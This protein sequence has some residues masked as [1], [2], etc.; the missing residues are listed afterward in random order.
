MEL[1]V[2]ILQPNHSLKDYD[3]T[4]IHSETQHCPYNPWDLLK[5]IREKFVEFRRNICPAWI[6]EPCYAA[7]WTVFKLNSAEVSLLARFMTWPEQLDI[8]QL[9]LQ[10]AIARCHPRVEH[11]PRW[12][13]SRPC[14][15]NKPD[16]ATS[17]P[18]PFLKHI[19]YFRTITTLDT[20]SNFRVSSDPKS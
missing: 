4:I 1:V 3:L 20:D 19:T 12:R 5:V 14:H 13:A 16:K 7:F 2:M 8:G 15:S 10:S 9:Q 11:K 17:N 18:P 6:Q